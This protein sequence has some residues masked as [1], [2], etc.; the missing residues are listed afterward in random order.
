MTASAL[1][2]FASQTAGYAVAPAFQTVTVTNTG[3]QAITLTQ[4][5]STNYTIGTLSTTGL[6]VNGTATFTVQPKTSLAAGTYNETISIAGSG[7]AST[8]VS[9]QFTVTPVATYTMTASAL[10]T[11]A[12]QIVGYAAAPALQT[13]TVTNTGN[14][15]ITLTQPTSNNYTIGTLST[16]NLAVG[17]TAT[18]TVTKTAL[19]VGS[20]NETINIAVQAARQQ[21]HPRSLPLTRQPIP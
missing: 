17:G 8:S 16:T 21:A 14:Q 13:V 1:T 6:T 5:T 7:S 20:Y 9:A 10:T 19:T 18:F 15:A 3:N 11:F 2:A 12:S 4:P